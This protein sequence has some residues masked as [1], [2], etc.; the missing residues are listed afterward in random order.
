MLI[1]LKQI[2]SYG[3]SN[4]YV[5]S[6]NIFFQKNGSVVIQFRGEMPRNEPPEGK[7]YPLKY[8]IWC[9]ENLISKMIHFRCPTQIQD[10]D[11]IQLLFQLYQIDPIKRHSINSILNF[12]FISKII[13][14]TSFSKNSAIRISDDS[15]RPIPFNSSSDSSLELFHKACK[16]RCHEVMRDYAKI[17]YSS[18]NVSSD[19]T[20]EFSSV[21]WI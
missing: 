19:H 9:L 15:L 1:C 5:D 20:M 10:A 16:K 21:E 11:A 12:P 4:A 2:H 7:D 8:D 13:S 17:S 18:W 6:S 14:T 3:I